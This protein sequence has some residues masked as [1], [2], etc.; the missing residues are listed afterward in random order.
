MKID[1]IISADGIVKSKIRDKIV[2]LIDMLRATSVIT[3]PLS[4]GVNRV[5]T[6]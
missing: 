3:T 6:F 4:N 5:I 1:V 2:M